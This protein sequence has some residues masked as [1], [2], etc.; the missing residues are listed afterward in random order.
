MQIS[1]LI[2]SNLFSRLRRMSSL[3]LSLILLTLALPVYG[4]TPDEQTFASPQ[5]AVNALV[6][7]AKNHDTNALHAIFG[8]T[9]HDLV[10]PDV[11]QAAGE[12]KK[13]VER[14]TEKTQL[15]NH[16]DSNVTLAIGADAWPFPIPLVKQDDKWFFD[17]AAGA[18]EILARRI[19]RDEIGAI[20]VC[21]AYV[22]A[23]RE[24]ASQDRLEDGV[25][26]YAQLL[27]STP[28]KHDGLYWPTQPGEAL[29]PLGPL[30][31]EAHGEGYH[32]TA[33]MLNDEQAPYHGYYF[34]ILTGQGKHAPGGAYDYV[35]NGR[36]L[37]GFALVAWPA[38]WG[39]TG[40]MTF[41]VNQQGK[42][43]QK[44]LGPSTFDIAKDITTYAPDDTWTPA[45]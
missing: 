44:N 14:L 38:K 22:A 41:I 40:V 36:M 29:S 20:N 30:I 3:A 13:F 31:A 2:K 43:Y 9:G 12:S 11:V 33:K 23:Q 8:P 35:I 26:A 32:H 19:G 16:S 10:S 34:K 37:A 42:V 25:L 7:A 17:T 18:Q 5:D 1:P 4:S 21:N 28:G 15:I 24:Y 6:I 27:H 39:S 45:Q